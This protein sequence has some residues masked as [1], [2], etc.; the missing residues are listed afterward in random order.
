MIPA[1]HIARRREPHGR[2]GVKVLLSAAV[3]LV[4]VAMVAVSSLALF[5]DTATVAGNTF[6]TGTVD[7]A[8]TPAAQVLT[9]TAM[10]P[11]DQVAAPLTVTNSGTLALRYAIVST[12]TEDVL[13]GE[14]VLTV[15]AG[16]TDCSIA[17]WAAGGTTIYSGPLGSAATS[18]VVGSSAAGA[19]TGDRTLAPGAGEVLCLNVTLPQ[20]STI[21][22]G[23]STT[24]T[25]E[26]KAEQTVNN[27]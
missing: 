14:L 24:A 22:Q 25:L 12:T 6:A 26:F 10:S 15:R 9:M 18:A 19:D 2:S 21:G 17:G 13:A 5:T 8:A 3:V 27:P 11:G 16:V 23:V 7:I 1:D 20:G 4:G